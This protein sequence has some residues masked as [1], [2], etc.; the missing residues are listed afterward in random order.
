MVD[1][2]LLLPSVMRHA[3]HRQA[4]RQ[5]R[6]GGPNGHWNGGYDHYDGDTDH[7]Y[8]CSH[9]LDGLGWVDGSHS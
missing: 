5:D 6:L 3:G 4:H 7:V 1:G 8:G 9:G 2:E